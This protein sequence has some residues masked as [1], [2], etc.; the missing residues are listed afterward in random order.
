MTMN[1]VVLCA[2]HC[3]TPETYTVLHLADRA[4]D[5]TALLQMVGMIECPPQIEDDTKAI[6]PVFHFITKYAW[7]NER[8]V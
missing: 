1:F 3:L 8:L 4:E 5:W 2:A 7:W 6:F